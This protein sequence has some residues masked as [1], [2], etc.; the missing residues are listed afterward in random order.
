MYS[1]SLNSQTF[2]T[3]TSFWSEWIFDTSRTEEPLQATDRHLRDPSKRKI[4]HQGKEKEWTVTVHLYSHFSR[5]E[6]LL[7]N[8]RVVTWTLIWCPQSHFMFWQ[9][10]SAHLFIDFQAP[11]WGRLMQ[12]LGQ[13]CSGSCMQGFYSTHTRR[14]PVKA[15]RQNTCSSTSVTS[16]MEGRWLHLNIALQA[17]VLS[18]MLWSCSLQHYCRLS[19]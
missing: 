3:G 17:D 2:S 8:L 12:G 18:S 5:K 1:V 14:S 4:K 9:R 7:L 11:L 10:T 15:N 16:D 6:K 13:L 19:L